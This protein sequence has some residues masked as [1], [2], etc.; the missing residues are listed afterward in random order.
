MTG[1]KKIKKIEELLKELPSPLDD[2]ALSQVDKTADI[3][4]DEVKSLRDA[5]YHFANWEETKEKDVFW[6]D[7]WRRAAKNTLHEHPDVVA[8]KERPKL[9][10]QYHDEGKRLKGKWKPTKEELEFLTGEK[11]EKLGSIK[12]STDNSEYYEE[13]F[14][15]CEDVLDKQEKQFPYKATWFDSMVVEVIQENDGKAWVKTSNGADS[16]AWIKDLHPIPEKPLKF[17]EWWK[18]K[19][20]EDFTNGYASVTVAELNLSY[21]EY[22]DYLK[23]FEG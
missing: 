16:F 12:A 1:S 23:D 3:W 19:Y 14:N 10:P 20:T 5:I 22:Q 15:G 2:W 6:E 17:G 13:L 8:Y 18:N 7:V 11:Q 9:K 21:Y 4:K